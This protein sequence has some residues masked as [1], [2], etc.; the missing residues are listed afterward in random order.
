MVVYLWDYL[1]CEEVVVEVDR[2][3][4]FE[5][6][7]YLTLNTAMIRMVVV[8]E[9]EV[10]VT[11]ALVVVAAAAVLVIDTHADADTTS[12]VLLHRLVVMTEKIVM[13]VLWETNSTTVT[14]MTSGSFD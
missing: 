3:L 11:V 10:V 8:E 7:R 13:T 1:P 5:T 14:T 4:V 9:E 6:W 12:L 2:V